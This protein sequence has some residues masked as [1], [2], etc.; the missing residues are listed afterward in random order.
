[1]KRCV[2]SYLHT[3][4]PSTHRGE[5]FFQIE[6]YDGA[7]F[8]SLTDVTNVTIILRGEND[9]APT[10]EFPEGFQI[11]VLE[12]EPPEIDLVVLLMYTTDPDFGSGGEFMFAI[13]NIYDS[14]FEND[15]FT[16]NE[17]TGLITTLRAFDR[18][19]QPEGIVV[20]IETTDF[21]DDPQS[22]VTNIT[23][24]IADINDNPPIF[25]SDAFA[26]VY[27]FL[28]PGVEVLSEYRA[29]DRDTGSNAQLEYEIF[30]G[31]DNGSFSIDPQTG[32]IFT[33]QEL[34]KTVQDFY[35]LSII[36]GD[37][38]NPQMFG[39]GQITI[40]VIDANDNVPTFSESLYEITLLENSTIGTTILQ[41]NASDSDVGTNAVIQY[42]LAPNSSHGERFA[43]NSSTGEIYTTDEF[44]RE[45][46]AFLEL[47]VV[48]IDDGEV[49]LTLTGSATVLITVGDLNDNPPQ[50]NETSYEASVVEN[51]LSGTLVI[52]VLANDTDAE[53]PN[54]VIRYS[55]SGNRSEAF[56][57]DPVSGDV[58]V[59]GEVDWE[60]GANFTLVVIATD[61]GDPPQS[62]EAE[63]SL[64]IEDVN[65]NSPTFVAE[66][67]NLSIPENSEVGRIV[68]CVKTED[69]DSN[70]NNSLH[71]YSII[72]DFAGGR[73]DLD[74][75][76]G[77]V[78]FVSGTLDREVRPSFDL[79]IQ[80][81]D[82]GSPQRSADAT[83]IITILDANDFDPV[84]DQDLY[85]SSVFENS[86]TGTSI[87]TVRA[88]D[89]HD[90]GANADLE[91]SILDPFFLQYFNINASTG[92]ISVGDNTVFF[93]FENITF[94]TFEVQVTDSRSDPRNDTTTVE[95]EI[96]DSNDHPP[97]FEQDEYSAV[98]RENLASG[99]TVLRVNASDVDTGNNSVI[100]YSIKPGLGS[101]D[102]GIHPETG[103]LYTA[104]YLNREEFLYYNLTI[105][106]NNSDAPISRFSEV[107]AIVNLTDLNDMHPSFDPVIT[108]V[109]V[110]ENTP[111]NLTLFSLLPADGDEDENGTV[112]YSLQLGNEDGVFGLD[113]LTGDITLLQELDFESRSLYVFTVMANDSG[114]PSLGN[115]TNVLVQ[116]T[117]S[118][119]NDPSFASPGGYAISVSGNAPEGTVI[120][121]VVAFD[122]DQGLN[123]ELTY[124]I[125]ADDSPGLFS[126]ES[127]AAGRLRT[128]SSLFGYDDQIFNLTIQASDAIRNTTTPVTVFIQRGDVNLPRFTEQ[129]FS[130]P[131][132]E[133]TAGGQ[134]IF[135]FSSFTENEVRDSYNIVNGN[136]DGIFNVTGT[137]I[138]KLEL[139]VLDFETQS[140]YQLS[141]SIA[142]SAGDV[143]YTIL[144][145]VVT[146]VNEY[147]PVFISDSFFAVVS[148]I[149]PARVPFFTVNA[150]DRDSSSPAN[151][152]TY[153]ITPGD[154]VLID[155]Q[156]GELS[157]SRE[158]DYQA[159][160]QSFNL[161]VIAANEATSPQLSTNTSIEIMVLKGN[162]FQ[163]V[164]SPVT[165]DI[166]LSED[167]AVGLNV[168]NVSASD[169][170][171]GSQGEITYGM[172]GD[173]RYLDFRIDT[174]NG[175]IFTNY[176]LDRERQTLYTLDIIASDGG[177]PNRFATAAV[178]IR[179]LDLNDNTPVWDQTQY[180]TSLIE[181]ITVGSTVISVGAMDLDQVDQFT[182]PDTGETTFSSR[183]GYVTY[184]ITD[185]NPENQ[186]GIDEDTGVVTIVSTL[187]REV[188]PEYNL[189][190]NATDGPGLFANAYLHIVVHDAN[191]QI[192]EFSE[193]PYQVGIPE[194]AENGTFVVQVAAVDTDLNQNSNFTFV[195]SGG[196]NGSTFTLNSTSGE[197]FLETSLNREAID[198]FTLVVEA[199]DM[200]T[201]PLT[202]TV[203]V[204]ITV[205]DINEFPPVFSAENYTGEVFENEPLGTPI[206]QVS[207][208]DMDFEENGTVQ[209][210]IIPG[211]ETER[212]NI[213]SSSGE[214]SVAGSLDFE[215]QETYDFIVMATD[216][217]P[218]SERLSSEVNVTVVIVDRND[219][220]PVFSPD[221]YSA[222][223]SESAFPGTEVISVEVTDAD[224][225]SNS[226]I[227]FSI[228][229][230]GDSE[231]E[232]NFVIEPQSGMIN[233]TT[234]VDLDRERT[235]SYDVIVIAMDQ[236]D[237]PRQ[238]TVPVT[239]AIADSNDNMPQFTQPFFEGALFE[240]LPAGTPAAVVSATDADIDENA[241]LE[242]EITA[243]IDNEEDCNL[244]CNGAEFCQSVFDQANYATQPNFPFYISTSN[245]TGEI[246]SSQTLDRENISNYILL[247]QANDSPLNETQL[248]STACVHVSILDR[249]DETPIFN[250]TLYEASISEFTG[251]SNFVVQVFASD[252]DISTNAEITFQLLSETG[253]FTV[254]PERGEI[255]TVGEYDRE[256]REVYNITIAASDGLLEGTAFVVV[257]ILD[258]N[259]NR[260]EFSNSL[261]FASIEENMLPN[262]PVIQ[263]NATDA[264]ISVNAEI[265]Y[266]VE[267]STPEN[268]FGINPTTGQLYTLQLLDREN[269]S[270]Y[271]VTILATDSGV[272]ALSTSV[273]VNVSVQDTNDLAPVFVGTPY[274]VQVEENS[275]QSG[276]IFT[277]QAD[278]GDV[279]TNAE[280]F[281]TLAGVEPEITGAF[282]INE[283]SG[284][285]FLMQ[286]LNA[287]ASLIYSL[288]VVADNGPA[289]P[290]Q[291]TEVTVTVI[292]LDQNDN[293]PQFRQED[294][295]TTISEDMG[296]GSVVIQL[297]AFDLDATDTNSRL[298]F[299][300]T[301]GF[302]TSLFTIDA[303]SGIITVEGLLDRESEPTHIL[304]VTVFDSGS[305][306][307]SSTATVTIILQDFNDNV[308][309]FEQ[310]AYTFTVVENQ[311]EM[312]SIGQVRAN[313]LDLQ[314][315]SYY[316]QE[317]VTDGSSFS[318]NLTTGEL[319]SAAVFDREAQEVYSFIIVATDNGIA[320]E[321][322][323]AV[324]ANVTVLDQNDVPPAF[325]LPLY[326]VSWL[327]N[328][329]TGTVL[330]TVEAFDP[331][332]GENGTVEYSI[333]QSNDSSFFSI[334]TTSGEIFLEQMLNREE[335]D[336]FQ[337]KV[338]VFD[339]GSP[340]LTGSATIELQ[341]LDNNDNI[342]VLNASEYQ[343]T[344]NEDTPVGSTV[345]Y[346]GASD[347]DIDE[348][349]AIR[350]SLSDDFDGTFSIGSE[351]G[352]VV[353]TR[354]LDYELIQSY[355][356]SVIA[357]DS[358]QEPLSS[359]S[360]F[361]I[362]IVDLNDNP[363]LFD[364]TLYQVSVPENAILNTPVF[365]IPATDAD[366]TSNGELRYTILSGNFEFK[367]AV[368]EVAGVISVADYLN[369]EITSSYSLSLQVV[370][371][372][373]PQFTA[374]TELEITIADVNDHPPEF[375]SKTYS[376][377]IP[378]LI[379]IGTAFFTFEPNDFDID[380]NANFSYAIVS[381]NSEAAFDIDPFLG[382]VIV[383]RNLDFETTPAYSL[384]VSVT[385]NGYPIP[386]SD[387]ANL[388]VLL[389]D[390]NE[391]PPL[392]IQNEYIAN[393]SQN[394]VIGA[395]IGFFIATDADVY[396]QT[397]I[398]YSLINITNDVLFS[399]DP[400]SGT[401]Y[402]RS[403]L[404][405][406]NVTLTFEA[407]D[408][409]YTI[410]TDIHITII[411]EPSDIPQFV[412]A[413][414]LLQV[415]EAT[416]V[417]TLIGQLDTTLSPATISSAS[418]AAIDE[419]FQVTSS[420][421]LIL[422][423]QL[424]R[425]TVPAYVFNVQSQSETGE[426]TFAI[427]TVQVIDHN[428]IT[429]V[430][431]STLYSVSVSELVP[432]GTTILTLR[433]FDRDPPGENSDVEITVAQGNEG[434]MFA[435]EPLSGALTILQTLD[436][437]TQS[438][439]TLIAN[440]TNNLASPKLFSTAE[441]I[442][443][444]L[445]VNDNNPEFSQMFYQIQIPETI[446][447][448]SDILILEASD[449]DS[450]TNSE[451]VFSITNLNIPYSFTINQTSGAISTNSTFDVGDT[452]TSY[453]ISAMV[454]DRGNPQ[455]RSD[456]TTIFVEVTPSNDFGPEFSQPD[457]FST[458]IP[459]TLPIGG[460]VLQISATDPDG[461][462]PL[463]LSYSI[464]AG[465]PRGI[466]E[467]D[468]LTGLISLASDIDFQEQSF[469]ELAVE[470][471]D[472]GTSSRSSV[473]TANISIIDINNNDPEFDQ[474]RYEVAVFE[475][476]TI[477]TLILQVFASDPDAT[478]LTYLLTVNA[479]QN[480]NQLFVLDN[481]TGELSTAASIDRE[482]D[483][484]LELLVTAID[485]GYPIQRSRS[486]PVVVSILDL[487]DNPPLFDQP[488]I[489]IPVLRLLPPRRF[490]ATVT[491]TD[492][493]LVGQQL[494][495]TITEDNSGS[496]FYINSTSG[497]ITT[498]SRVPEFTSPDVLIATP[499][500]YELTLSAFDGVFTTE[501]MLHMELA[502]QGEFCEGKKKN[503]RGSLGL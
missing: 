189:T 457:G 39:F 289:L 209:F 271:L 432:V 214:I 122:R 322:T 408:G 49:P 269:I 226:Q 109:S 247:V 15:S 180:F 413:A 472:F 172:H 212:F 392:F 478:S 417:N 183:N 485:S 403:E 453:V 480:G 335:Q 338:S 471:V 190:L 389:T 262:S 126:L 469:Y 319:F 130:V 161:T 260:P 90:I 93:D 174:F 256:T 316:F 44:D 266:T 264:D 465:D 251:D 116:V 492:A 63:I 258:E 282:E 286:S 12:H 138:V 434:G 194:D 34:N 259:D 97:D 253:S 274:L 80:A 102:F 433:A 177:N 495:Y 106:A 76:S 85:Y 439:F 245:L 304:E 468:P 208:S 207:A 353:L 302:N 220:R 128:E 436:S 51:E 61:L 368:N 467:I 123:A 428:D 59:N 65:D 455:P 329:T 129:S 423:G 279:L 52:S 233:L 292:V 103:V 4:I 406:T 83:L 267:S 445:D 152:I 276:A 27:E 483:D 314:V 69:R 234:N 5:I 108:K 169:E 275:L 367:F 486:V 430:F 401:L 411:E 28:P 46:D 429:P 48:A 40:E 364:S 146:D 381:G 306:A 200:G 496:L 456:V 345:A 332:L 215:Q 86:P 139:P 461:T 164:F 205:L 376:I 23:I 114:T 385:D 377:F 10:I 501:G 395:P 134:S 244:T 1:M 479:Y 373:S 427:V 165:Y 201:V 315:I 195:L 242:F 325:F 186:F 68:G 113:S 160:D 6:A 452:A 153:D 473:V 446:A 498:T 474:A 14:L 500:A 110:P 173:H 96:A 355:N 484:S 2:L 31:N 283:T 278:D 33:A 42:F 281:F 25:E 143:A 38:G 347:E 311:P 382:R 187:D 261:F 211:N 56:R 199:R 298:M 246:F 459:D 460:S 351:S 50:F 94:V 297:E 391:H 159:G 35:N 197:I 352:I 270:E 125:T 447:L 158:V 101:S 210:V 407:T 416:D 359:S 22:Q 142:N 502:A 324:L 150:T 252:A 320:I 494:S 36:A 53:E 222:I 362:E 193:S 444:I 249:N 107:Q 497:E 204:Q 232:A 240:N 288:T 441:I 225:G 41:V 79:F 300:I 196:N 166:A 370:D 374:N 437:E 198:S 363:P 330:L 224:S 26:M 339:F 443:T 296:N 149:L 236:G 75:E 273:Q 178:S 77:L 346:I 488:V 424:D 182:D 425:E 176:P 111:V 265:T 84:F 448:G 431:E 321:R 361:L 390:Q 11:L 435:L 490:V 263:L 67:L 120:A 255:F 301:G 481:S 45:S 147:A 386:L 229:F 72:M 30:A 117:D 54:N 284:E 308:P 175:S 327:E 393:V 218:A 144:D 419:I 231:A 78:T 74:K 156:T 503:M 71:S 104:R 170:D 294:Y 91:Y 350:F 458:E 188:F 464:Q 349:A 470:A 18:E 7:F 99:T 70:G 295:V 127:S 132:P 223:V 438:T 379:E 305:P 219:N 57:V 388:R 115:Y 310:S 98:L 309:V 119:D 312:T 145:V 372:G 118:N 328:T 19:L 366:S 336:F 399:L 493:D 341:V 9:E 277:V 360:S 348:N 420:G 243:V 326:N 375:G 87:L 405:P 230:L 3:H 213:N 477:G 285:L 112:T 250:Q 343:A 148:E 248:S 154:L 43:V 293:Q 449:S 317:N 357:R 181:N 133:D 482:L 17:T 414:Y 179:I 254:H 155:S 238:A 404:Y 365:L 8:N 163:P 313:D 475:N 140:L 323:A 466:F 81:T 141:I 168:V 334:N 124:A 358:A 171:I 378:E 73:F 202:G 489:T 131:I 37:Q 62:A 418:S 95:I 88:T 318:I 228:D 241:A 82:H 167:I 380:Q 396:S 121:T 192:P 21:G 397:Q 92:V 454:A 157:L 487:N 191:D 307:M 280:I 462:V 100:E 499:D 415:S 450:G 387:I 136:V 476:T 422:I 384:S 491:A 342:P 60:E 66:T 239:I 398:T 440:V 221:S 354:S 29:I 299:E 13:V 356:F 287:E 227:V 463:S 272:P 20:A 337:F 47:I 369:R 184:S 32:G 55:L 257:T 426:I 303:I 89:D 105:I 344:L 291:V 383:S 185:G 217:A 16:I 410:Q 340:R 290:E 64:F 331:D 268:H 371:L 451:L 402:V 162:K 235:Q 24:M 421:K 409:V 442:I 58:F 151:D 216:S 333:T 203:D 206:L 394:A 412:S 237:P 135:E 400:L 137:G